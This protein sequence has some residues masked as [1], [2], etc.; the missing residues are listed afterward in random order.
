MHPEKWHRKMPDIGVSLKRNFH[1]SKLLPITWKRRIVICA[2]SAEKCKC[3]INQVMNISFIFPA[4]KE[5]DSWL[6]YLQQVPSPKA[7]RWFT[8]KEIVPRVHGKVYRS[9]YGV[10]TW[11]AWF[12]PKPLDTDQQGND[13]CYYLMGD[14]CQA[15]ILSQREVLMKATNKRWRIW[16]TRENME[17]VIA[18]ITAF[19]G[20]VGGC[21]ASDFFAKSCSKRNLGVCS[22]I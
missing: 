6:R 8:E 2:S 12:V 7:L 13:N 5:Q 9:L 1:I 20:G 11:I 10:S 14:F 16:E 18:W 22:V 4:T 3:V 19:F 21:N 15:T 17:L